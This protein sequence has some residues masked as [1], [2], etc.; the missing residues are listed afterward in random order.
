MMGFDE[1]ASKLHAGLLLDEMT[2][3]GNL[4]KFYDWHEDHQIEF[5]VKF[6]VYS[7]S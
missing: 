3:C 4:Y 2:T 7:I 6:S 5:H 1:V